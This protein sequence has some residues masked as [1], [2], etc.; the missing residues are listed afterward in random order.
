MVLAMCYI[1]EAIVSLAWEKND[2][3][4]YAQGVRVLRVFGGLIIIGLTSLL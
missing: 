4:W 2:K 1:I 3:S